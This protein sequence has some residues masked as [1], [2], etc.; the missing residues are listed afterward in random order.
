MNNAMRQYRGLMKL[1]AVA[2]R[3]SEGQRRRVDELEGARASAGDALHRLEAAIRTEEAVALGRTEIGFRDLAGYLAG[4]AAKREAL[5]ATC[6]ALDAEIAAAR[7]A[8]TAAEIERRK[9][10]HLCDLRA[11]ALRKRRD[12]REGALLEEAGRRQAVARSGRF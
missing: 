10:D 1:L 4:A 8:L 11:A 2:R 3:T 5:L 12:K 7:E 9:L 6:R